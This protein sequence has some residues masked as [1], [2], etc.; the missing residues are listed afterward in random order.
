VKNIVLVVLI[1]LAG[2]ASACTAPAFQVD[3]V[4]GSGNVTRETRSVGKFSSIENT[5]A[6]EVQ[7]SFGEAESVVVEAEDNLLPYIETEVKGRTLTIHTKPNTSIAS[8]RPVRIQVTIQSLESANLSSSGS[9]GIDNV[10]AEKLSL[11]LSSSGTIMATGAVDELTVTLNSSGT[12]ACKDLQARSAS[13]T[14][15]SSG[16]VT[17]FV[18]DSLDITLTGSGSVVYGGDP[19]NVN[20]SVTGSGRVEAE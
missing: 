15:N 1:V 3:A 13:V 4:E 18:R 11:D 17:V 7:V 5:I 12:I 2:L 10:V 20:Q 19:A 16:N 9:I 14:N 6:A 8:T